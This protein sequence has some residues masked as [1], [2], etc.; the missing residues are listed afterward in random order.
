MSRIHRVRNRNTTTRGATKKESKAQ[1]KITSQ[2]HL[3]LFLE[4]PRLSLLLQPFPQLSLLDHPLRRT[5]RRLFRSTLVL[6]K[7]CLQRRK[8]S[9][10][11]RDQLTI[12]LHRQ[13]YHTCPRRELHEGRKSRRTKRREREEEKRE[14]EEGGAQA[15]NEV[16]KYKLVIK[17]VQPI[18]ISELG[19]EFS[20]V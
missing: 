3:Q 17:K 16:Y 12:P 8:Q 5:F 1:N 6:Q 20:I 19:D 14:E 10:E 13:T 9:P 18:S 2:T 4:L 15:E 7:I 11:A